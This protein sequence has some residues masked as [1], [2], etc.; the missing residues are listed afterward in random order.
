VYRDTDYKG[1]VGGHYSSVLSF[2]TQ[3]LMTI[4]N[5]ILELSPASA[6]PLKSSPRPRDDSSTCPLS[7]CPTPLPTC[8]VDTTSRSATISDQHKMGEPSVRGGSPSHGLH[9]LSPSLHPPTKRSSSFTLLPSTSTATTRAA[10]TGYFDLAST[11]V[12]APRHMRHE[13]V[14]RRQHA[15]S[16]SV[17][18][19][20]V[21]GKG[22]VSQADLLGVGPSRRPRSMIEAVEEHQEG[23]GTGTTRSEAL[24]GDRQAGR[25]SFNSVRPVHIDML[26]KEDAAVLEMRFDYMTD[27]ELGVYLATLFPLPSPTPLTRSTSPARAPLATPPSLGT[28]TPTP[29]AEVAGEGRDEMV[30]DTPRAI[31]TGK[32]I[33]REALWNEDDASPLFPPSPP[34]D[35]P[36]GQPDHPLRILARAVR[37]L[38]DKVEQLEDENERLRAEISLGKAKRSKSHATDQVSCGRSRCA[39]MLFSP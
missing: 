13:G 25:G 17:V 11:S 8:H 34:G 1:I 37:E 36:R 3:F 18:P 9:P 12:P 29:S 21:A 19:S 20:R 2:T 10:A 35:M 31:K 24:E 4:T 30:P 33:G 16:V 5:P 23:E 22:R 38:K 6:S 32:R 39:A 28:S 7:S 26:S 15:A 27:E 14:T